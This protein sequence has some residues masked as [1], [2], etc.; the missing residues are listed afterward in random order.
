MNVDDAQIKDICAHLN[1]TSQKYLGYKTPAEV[2]RQ[3]VMAER[4][5]AG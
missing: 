1:S 5:K 4:R 2:F 3:K